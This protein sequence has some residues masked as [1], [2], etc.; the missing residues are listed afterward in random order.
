MEGS[1][2]S[3]TYASAKSSFSHSP[4]D[5]VLGFSERQSASEPSE[6]PKFAFDGLEKSIWA[7]EPEIDHAE[8]NLGSF[9]KQFHIDV[10]NQPHNI[11]QPCFTQ[12]EGQAVC[13]RPNPTAR[14]LHRTI[15]LTGLKPSC[16][17][18]Q[19]LNHVCGGLIVEAVLMN[20]VSITGANSALISFFEEQSARAFKAYTEAYPITIDHQNIVVYILPTASWPL[21]LGLKR[22]IREHRHTRCLKIQD[23]PSNVSLLNLRQDLELKPFVKYQS[24]DG[25]T[26]D[27]DRTLVIRFC[28][29]FAA[30]QASTVLMSMLKQYRCRI[31][32]AE[33]PCARPID[34]IVDD[35][36]A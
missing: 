23:F 9:S 7:K 18:S 20:T 8:V 19:V 13:Y 36:E 6:A 32:F 17:I 5:D 31:Q 30:Q 2:N 29:I 33:D 3:S 15:V 27:A 28:S 34:G 26:M 4:I 14:N 12:T 35:S 25:M 16:S 10:P 21:P 22:N 24:I 1:S 11:W